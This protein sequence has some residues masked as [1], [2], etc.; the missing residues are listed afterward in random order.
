M[1]FFPPHFS[2]LAFSKVVWLKKFRFGLCLIFGLFS[3][4]FLGK[5]QKIRNQLM[6][7]F[8]I[9]KLYI[10]MWLRQLCEFEHI[11]NFNCKTN[12]AK[13]RISSFWYYYYLVLL[14]LIT[15]LRSHSGCAERVLKWVAKK[16]PVDI[17]RLRWGKILG[18][19]GACSPETFL[20]F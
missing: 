12:A 7:C 19:P 3:G 13:I 6:E 4:F 16:E 5:T 8:L 15:A 2:I 20:N 17:L 10:Y 14:L 1:A 9:S 18:G 11:C